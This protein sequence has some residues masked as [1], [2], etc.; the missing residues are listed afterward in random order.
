MSIWSRIGEF[1]SRVSS[2][3]LAGVIEALRTTFSSDPQLQRNVAFS[4]AMIALSAKMAK[5]DGVVTDD[6]VKAFHRL[7]EVPEGEFGNVQRL[8]NLAKQDVAGFEA[9][10][11]RLARL[12]G[13][14]TENCEMLGDILDGLFH[15]ATADGFL[16]EREQ[17]FLARVADI[18]DIDQEH[19]DAI[20]RRH[21]DAG[22]EDPYRI[23]GV[24]RDQSFDEIRRHY[25]RLVAEN[26]PDRL[27]ARGVPAE[28]VA[29]ANSR[30]A[31]LNGAFERIERDMR[32]S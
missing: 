2:T 12:C 28:F 10:A 8:F 27:I 4:I 25:R 21:V 18:F 19:F 30:L 32:V 11:E 1:V 24:S 26:H 29:I 20:L 31:A 16:H 9:Y 5:A 23:L 17:A 15:I 6:E 22:E 13:S 3:T 14:G 7:F